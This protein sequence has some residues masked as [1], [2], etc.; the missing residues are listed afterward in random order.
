MKYCNGRRLFGAF[1]FC[2]HCIIVRW[3]FVM[4]VLSFDLIAYLLVNHLDD[5]AE[6]K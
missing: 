4:F 1:Q 3:H 6:K 5:I 2:W